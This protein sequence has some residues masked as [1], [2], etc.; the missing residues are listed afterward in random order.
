MRWIYRLVANAVKEYKDSEIGYLYGE[1]NNTNSATK[2]SLHTPIIMAG[3][4]L[5]QT[6]IT[7][8][9]GNKFPK[10]SNDWKWLYNIVKDTLQSYFDCGYQIIIVTNQAGIKSDPIKMSEFKQKIELIE[11]DIIESNPT[12]SFKIY[13]A[14]HK[15]VHRKPYPTLLEGFNIDRIVSFF[16]GDGAGRKGDHTSG[17]I[18]FAYNLM[19]NFKTPEKLFLN[20]NSSRGIIEY[21]FKQLD[22]NLTSKKYIFVPNLEKRPELI[23]MVGLPASGKSYTVKQLIEHYS[24]QG[25]NVNCLSLDII[26]SKPKMLN[27]IKDFA[28]RCNSI[29]IDNTNLDI[30]T[31]SSLIKLVKDIKDIY[32]VRIINIDTSLDRCIHNNYYR[33]YKNY[34]TDPKFIPD[35]VYKMMAN[36]YVIPTLDENNLIDKIDVIKPGIPLD[37]KY[38]YYYF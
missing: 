31:R 10:N 2:D 19:I 35:F 8:V 17:D 1:T 6:L 20:D 25:V 34:K 21:P 22:K 36:K 9:S 32:Y 24:L 13:C 5:D 4:D 23:I 28:S 3:F 18:K 33:Y 7:T 15:D 38:I 16:C 11:R 29:I 37:I 26:K 27:M 14:V 12:L 30:I